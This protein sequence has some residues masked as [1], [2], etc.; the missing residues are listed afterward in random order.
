MI[1]L[2]TF[3][4]CF[5]FDAQGKVAQIDRASSSAELE[6]L[7]EIIKE[8][9]ANEASLRGE[10]EALASRVIEQAKHQNSIENELGTFGGQ[11]ARLESDFVHIRSD[12]EMMRMILSFLVRSDSDAGLRCIDSW[13]LKQR[14]DC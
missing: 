9:D 12:C 5:H 11:V 7:K 14:F 13:T 10:L 2:N 6:R 4:G 1:E 3:S 8:R